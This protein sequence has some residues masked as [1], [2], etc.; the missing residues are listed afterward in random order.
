MG[1]DTSSHRTCLLA[2]H[3]PTSGLASRLSIADLPFRSLLA[4]KKRQHVEGRPRTT[5]LARASSRA[6][7][8]G[9]SDDSRGPF[10]DVF[11]VPRRRGS[12]SSH[13]E[14]KSDVYLLRSDGH[15]C[16][17]ETVTCT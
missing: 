8:Q 14:P 3:A 5:G 15:S 12:R 17:R 7:A 10:E 16:A 6:V 4:I 11:S 13:W 1:C 2:S 9:R